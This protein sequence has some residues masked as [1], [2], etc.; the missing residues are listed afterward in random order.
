MSRYREDPEYREKVKK[1]SA[2]R[3]E[4]IKR[5][6]RKRLT[7]QAT[8]GD[9][10]IRVCRTHLR[11]L[12]CEHEPHTA[13][14]KCIC[15]QGHEIKAAEDS[16]GGGSWLCY[17]LKEQRFYAVVKGD[18]VDTPQITIDSVEGPA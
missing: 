2:D 12:L 10:F 11:E 3:R 9:R 14:V 7:V 6:G 1:R 5:E 18:E 8:S 16:H 13:S 4:R 17:D 15:P